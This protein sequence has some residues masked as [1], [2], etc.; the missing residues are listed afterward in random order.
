MQRW[1]LAAR[2]TQVRPTLRPSYCPLPLT[3]ECQ[4]TLALIVMGFAIAFSPSFNY[5]YG[6]TLEVCIA[7]LAADIALFGF[8]A[9]FAPHRSPDDIRDVRIY[10][11]ILI[12]DCFAF[13][14]SLAAGIVSIARR[15]VH[16]SPRIANSFTLAVLRFLRRLGLGPNRPSRPDL[17]LFPLHVRY[18]PN[19]L[20][21]PFIMVEEDA[22]HHPS[23]SESFHIR[24]TDGLQH[25]RVGAPATITDLRTST[26]LRSVTLLRTIPSVRTLSARC[27][28][29]H[30][31]YP[32]Q[33]CG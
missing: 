9:L 29:H 31:H 3:S 19:H 18:W 24:E 21:N 22:E 20:P 28:V 33:T 12:I 11:L 16:L 26:S 27:Q 4:I 13:I 6:G 10:L 23:S 30:R 32:L 17:L 1:I 25:I 14:M 8:L 2:I 15:A 7:F 5:D